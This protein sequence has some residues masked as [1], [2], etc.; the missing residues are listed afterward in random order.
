MALHR[1]TTITIG[2]P[3]VGRRPQRTTRSSASTPPGDGALR[4][5]STAASSSGSCRHRTR[6]LIELGVGVDDA[7]DLGRVAAALARLGV[8]VERAR[9]RR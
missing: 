6:R 1:L 5:A 2:V 8:A 9:R 4:H 3:D 7:D